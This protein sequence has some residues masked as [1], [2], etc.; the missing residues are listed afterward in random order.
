MILGEVVVLRK[1]YSLYRSKVIKD[2]EAK[3]ET[4][5]TPE[6]QEQRATREIK[7][8]PEPTDAAS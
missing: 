7:A 5:A 4:K 1:I 3:K 2:R 6:L 8:M